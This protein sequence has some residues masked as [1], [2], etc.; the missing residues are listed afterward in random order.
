MAKARR[1]DA[2]LGL[3]AQVRTG[4]MEHMGA[5]TSTTPEDDGPG[6]GPCKHICMPC[7]MPFCSEALELVQDGR[8]SAQHEIIKKTIFLNGWALAW[9]ASSSRGQD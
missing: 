8:A 1:R 5:Q 4:L 6:Q 7:A 9:E 2:I 3:S